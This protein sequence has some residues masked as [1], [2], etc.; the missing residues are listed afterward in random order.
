MREWVGES[1]DES[2]EAADAESSRVVPESCRKLQI[3]SPIAED[4]MPKLK[5][6]DLSTKNLN[7]TGGGKTSD[8]EFA[9]KP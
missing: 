2:A 4:E 8:V 9:M 6:A 1:G 3:V 5:L 7:A